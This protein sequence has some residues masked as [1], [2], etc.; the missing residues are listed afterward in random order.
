MLDDAEI[1]A[2]EKARLFT[3]WAGLAAGLEE[4]AM[5]ARQKAG[6][7]FGMGSDAEATAWREVADWLNRKANEK[8]QKQ[9]EF[10]R[11]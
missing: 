4:A 2:Q 11:P 10:F 5:E 3:H 6:I 9:Q 8:R 7:L 1:E